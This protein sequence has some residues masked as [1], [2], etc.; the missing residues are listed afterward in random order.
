MIFRTNPEKAA[1]ANTKSMPRIAIK[2]SRAFRDTIV[3]ILTGMIA[4]MLSYVLNLYDAMVLFIKTY[5]AYGLGDIFISLV[6]LAAAL[7]VFSWRRWQELNGEIIERIKAQRKLNES[8]TQ[9]QAVLDGVPDMIMQVDKDLRILWA[10]KEVLRKNPDAKYRPAYLALAYDKGTFIDS[11]CKWA[12]ELGK[13][14]KNITYQPDMVGVDGVSYWET[15]GVPVEDKEKK[16]YGAI[17]IAR[18]ITHRMR[19][20]HTWNLLSSIVESTDDAMFGVSWEG[21]IVSWNKGAEKTYGFLSHEIIGKPI[22]ILEPVE[23]RD[24]VMYYIDRVMKT[25]TV[26]KFET[27]RIRKGGK[28]IRISC[29]ICTFV[30]ATGKKLGISSIDRDITEAKLAEEALRESELFNKTIISSVGE[31]VIVYDSQLRY[32]V[33]NQFMEE[34]TGV[35][36]EQILGKNALEGYP[37]IFETSVLDLLK[38]A[39]KGQTVKSDG[40]KYYIAKSQKHGWISVSYSP[41]I[42][43]RGEIIG[44]VGIIRDITGRKESENALI[45][46]ETRFKELFDH[47]SSGVYVFEAVEDGS[48]FILTNFNKGGEEIEK[49]RKEDILG[50]TAASIAERM[51]AGDFIKVLTKV[52]KTGEPEHYLLTLQKKDGSVNWRDTYI[53]KLPSGE[54]V[55][56]YDDITERR[57]SEMAIKESEEKYRTFVQNFKGLAIR[58]TKNGTPVFFH[59]SVQEFTGYRQEDF[60]SEKILWDDLVLPE[61]RARVREEFIKASTINGYESEL[62]YRIIHKNGARFW[63][64]ESLK[65]LVNDK[66]EIVYIQATMYDTTVR[67]EA[68]Y[69]IKNSREQLRRLANHLETAREEERK[70]IAQEVHDELGYALTAIKLDISWLSKK[71]NTEDENCSARLKT[72]MELAETTLSKVRSISTMLRPPVLDH[73]GISA[74][75]EWAANDFQKRTAVRCKVIISPED[76]RLEENVTIAV[77][78]IF[79]EAL[80][81]ITRHANAS[82][83]DVSFTDE[84]G[85]IVLQ[86]KDNGKGIAKKQID[87]MKSLGI[88]GMKEKAKNLGGSLVITGEKG[89]GT[90]VTLTIPIHQKEMVND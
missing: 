17:A 69:E 31:G 56:I 22:S 2:M 24:E 64:L 35:K 44:V 76:I 42:S 43:A 77:F 70:K 59:G 88:V 11:T 30:D 45:Q 87:T 85:T 86:V 58:W 7:V 80:T 4:F 79:Q 84:N 12:I 53:Y 39:L 62:E 8:K 3:I 15:I 65:N 32:I 20:E 49:T 26:H 72:M 52:W 89:I 18:D 25:N 37:D 78:R 13:I 51:Q 23:L 73:F 9:L 1:M 60:V 55:T 36:A 21:V 14:E 47:M 34:L 5:N 28:R 50:K 61:D 40:S 63:V 19:H 81:N 27:D 29:N 54:V 57:H 82:R 33:W 90:T 41:H 75:I 48:D 71:I 67:K 46:S 83:V 68:E 74:A 66:Q 16:V 6:F 10:N 38:K